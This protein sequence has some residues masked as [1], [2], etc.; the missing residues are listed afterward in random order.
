MTDVQNNIIGTVLMNMSKS[1]VPVTEEHV[2]KMVDMLDQNGALFGYAPLTAE[3]R[4]EVIETL[5]A[6]LLLRIDRGHYV[7]E[8]NHKP[9]YIAAKAEQASDFWD[10][11]ML[12]LLKEKHWSG[13]TV[14][15]LDKTTDEIMDLLGNP[16]SPE[17]FSRRGLCIG[18]VQSGKT[19]TYIGLINKAADACEAKNPKLASELRRE[20]DATWKI[21]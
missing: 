9:W 2:A 1:T 8:K 16:A 3:E 10:R 20:G 21:L 17:G 18:D 12:Y 13:N 5:H 11:Y 6:K 4:E 14:D 19:S 7:K 15:E